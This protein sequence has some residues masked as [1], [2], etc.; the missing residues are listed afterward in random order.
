MVSVVRLQHYTQSW[1]FLVRETAFF[2]LILLPAL[3]FTCVTTSASRWVFRLCV[4]C[5]SMRVERCSLFS[6][7]SPCPEKW[8]ELTSYFIY[9]LFHPTSLLL[10]RIY[11]A[12]KQQ[13]NCSPVSFSP[14]SRPC[15]LS[16]PCFTPC[17]EH[18]FHLLCTPQDKAGAMLGS[19]H[20]APCLVKIP[21]SAP[22]S[23]DCSLKLVVQNN[24]LWREFDVQKHQ[25]LT[26]SLS[27][28]PSCGSTVSRLCC[29]GLGS[30]LLSSIP[31]SSILSSDLTSW[32]PLFFYPRSGLDKGGT[33]SC[34]W[35][36]QIN[37]IVFCLSYGWF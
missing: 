24:Q 34:R 32:P 31:L 16:F 4:V 20:T 13:P 2:G 9:A 35:D 18:T 6:F 22:V 27:F 3:E 10:V 15:L 12:R 30:F 23:W 7:P 19:P 8:L 14:I 28:S 11:E 1:I 37:C 5:I 36:I 17:A 33:L 25:D 26:S 21:A 29:P